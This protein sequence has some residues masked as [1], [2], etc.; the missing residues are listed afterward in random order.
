MSEETLLILLALIYFWGTYTTQIVLVAA[1]LFVLFLVW[2][3]RAHKAGT[4]QIKK[5]RAMLKS[6][7]KGKTTYASIKEALGPPR[8]A[9][10]GK[11][12]EVFTEKGSTRRWEYYGDHTYYLTCE[13]GKDDIVE[14][15]TLTKW[16]G[17]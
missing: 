11:S 4:E 9:F 10:L 17:N 15:F 1:V 2:A 14:S 5:E 8:T 3:V 7:E 12:P 13:F 6:I 16:N